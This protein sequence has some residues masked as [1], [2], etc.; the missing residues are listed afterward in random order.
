MSS[1]LVK[2]GLTFAA[3]GGVI[4]GVIGVIKSI[5]PTSTATTLPNQQSTDDD[6]DILRYDN[7]KLDSVVMEALGRF[8]SYKHLCPHEYR[9]ILE[10]LNDLIGLQI[11]INSG[12]IEPSYSYRATSLAEKIRMA[13]VRAKS[14]AR[15][16]SVTNFDSDETLINSIAG[17]YTYNISRDVDQYMLSRRTQ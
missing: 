5:I 11:S 15:N 4:G 12:K 7:L 1:E 16:I 8:K 3:I 9:T 13:L 2:N 6:S 14:K 17:D 10:S